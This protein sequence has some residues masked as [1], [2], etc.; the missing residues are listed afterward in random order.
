MLLTAF[1]PKLQEKKKENKR[2]EGFYSR[3]PYEMSVLSQTQQNSP[4][5]TEEAITNTLTK[6]LR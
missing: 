3:L 5:E 4:G 2:A 6:M 1:G